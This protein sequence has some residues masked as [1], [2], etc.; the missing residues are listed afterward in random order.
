MTLNSGKLTSLLCEC[1]EQEMITISPELD[2]RLLQNWDSF[3]H[4]NMIVALE[5]VFG[6][7]F[8]PADVEAIRTVK[9]ITD[10]LARLGVTI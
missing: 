1:F 8:M 2:I 9:D 3:N 5:E 10:I 6:V 7:T 4:I